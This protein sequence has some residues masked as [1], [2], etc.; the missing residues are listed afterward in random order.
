MNTELRR[1]DIEEQ[2]FEVDV[3]TCRV[4]GN[5]TGKLKSN[6]NINLDY[7]PYRLK[8]GGGVEPKPGPTV[9]TIWDTSGVATWVRD[10]VSHVQEILFQGVV[11]D[12]LE[13]YTVLRQLQLKN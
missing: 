12:R 9:M 8:K 2:G 5:F 10:G 7:S 4:E 6:S 3:I 13:L 11:E 1:E